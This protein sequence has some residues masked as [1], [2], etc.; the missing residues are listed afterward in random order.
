MGKL[1]GKTAVITGAAHGLG[2]AMAELFASEGA[3]VF[4]SDMDGKGAEEAAS[5][6]HEKGGLAQAM[7]ADVRDEATIQ[8]LASFVCERSSSLEILANNAGNLIRKDF[9]HLEDKDW[10]AVLDTHL[11]GTIR[12]TRA[13]LP[14]LQNAG[15]AG[16]AA[17]VN[18]ASIMAS[19]HFRQ[20]SSYSAAKAAIE[21][22]SRSLALEFAAQGIRVNYICPGFVPTAMTRQF[23]RP[24]YSDSLIKRIPMRRFG[25][26]EEIASLALFLS[27]DD[28]SYITG[29]GITA[30]GGLSINLV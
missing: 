8:R 14:P 17:V 16:G 24:G 12:T 15:Q 18:I 26:P 10:A 29:Q 1:Q 13:L 22:L 11:W 4:L 9:R 19:N 2:R 20:V 6:I 25:T 7:E 28:S 3:F 23:T 30:D 5:A 21:G 27:S